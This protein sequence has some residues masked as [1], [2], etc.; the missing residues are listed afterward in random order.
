MGLTEKTPFLYRYFEV[1]GQNIICQLFYTKSQHYNV[2]LRFCTEFSQ[3][4][5][6][7]VSMKEMVPYTALGEEGDKVDTGDEV[8][9]VAEKRSK[10]LKIVR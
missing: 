10:V 4:G 5:T 1:L 7:S 2:T 6:K 3:E 9:S 8:L